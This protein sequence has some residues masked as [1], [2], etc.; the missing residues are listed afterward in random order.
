M[1]SGQCLAGVLSLAALAG[2]GNAPQSPV[3]ESVAPPAQ[4]APPAVAHSDS[5]VLPS[6]P[7]S[8]PGLNPSVHEGFV[9]GITLEA[10]R[11]LT[12][13]PAVRVGGGGD[14]EIYRWTDPD[15]ATFTARFDGGVLVTRSSLRLPEGAPTESAQLTDVGT[16]PVAQIAPGVY[17]P[18]E[19]AVASA[20]EQPRGEAQAPA[21]PEVAMPTPE[22][23]APEAAPT[24]DGPVLAVGGAERRAREGAETSSYRPRA[25]LPRFTRSLPEGRFEMRFY[26]PSKQP[27]TAAIRRER[28]GRDVVVPPEGRASI[29]LDR[30]GYLLY[31]LREEEPYTLFEGPEISIDGF[32]LTDVEVRLDPEDVNVRLIDYSL[33]DTTGSA[34]DEH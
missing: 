15:G 3:S 11:G 23:P 8:P 34:A 10:A 19:R 28:L 18:L 26:N 9:R 29:M 32:A 21:P 7:A 16:L 17:I 22:T 31:F 12:E 30:G 6:V 25:S 33:P 4:T 13:V 27:A 2:C 1:K 5:P 20:T 14:T 24:P